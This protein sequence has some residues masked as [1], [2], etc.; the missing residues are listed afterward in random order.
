M[1]TPTRCARA[2]GARCA[3]TSFQAHLLDTKRSVSSQDKWRALKEAF[4]RQNLPNITNI[5]ATILIFLV[6]IY[7]QG[8]RVDL[9]V[10]YRSQRGM[11]VAPRAHRTRKCAR[12]QVRTRTRAHAHTTRAH[13][14]TAGLI[15]HQALLHVEHAHHPADGPRLQL[16]LCLAG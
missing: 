8:F 16:V 9:P 1:H 14:H 6:V 2:R 12:A 11:Q 15:P 5:M 13:A 10:K 3:A 4:Y 7:F